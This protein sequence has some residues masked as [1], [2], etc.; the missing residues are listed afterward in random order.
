[1]PS[2]RRSDGGRCPMPRPAQMATVI[3]ANALHGMAAGSAPGVEIDPAIG[4]VSG[5]WI[6]L[7]SAFRSI[8]GALWRSP[9]DRRRSLP[10]LDRDQNAF[11][12]EFR[13]TAQ[14]RDVFEIGTIDTLIV[15]APGMN[16]ANRPSGLDPVMT[17]P[18]PA[19]GCSTGAAALL[20]ADDLTGR[21]AT[22]AAGGRTS[23]PS[24]RCTRMCSRQ[25][26]PASAR[27]QGI[28]CSRRGD[29]ARL[30]Q[31]GGL[32]TR[33]S[34]CRRAAETLDLDSLIERLDLGTPLLVALDG[35]TDPHNLGAVV[36][37]L[38]P[39]EPTV[40]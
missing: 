38:R 12:S 5:L 18:F 40:W 14:V 39:W 32:F 26:P 7:Q 21:H 16:G 11:R 13:T 36:A 2:N 28:G 19:A 23:H 27:C 8:R 1:M 15:V 10:F 33:A 4:L 34:P 22:Q 6:A 30:G 9:P 24:H 37:P 17:R 25:I 35:V 20:P 29:L 31:T 3:A